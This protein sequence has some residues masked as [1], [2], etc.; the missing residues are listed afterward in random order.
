MLLER[1]ICI[2]MIILGV[3]IIIKPLKI[4]NTIRTMFILKEL[5]PDDIKVFMYR[6]V[7]IVNCI[8]FSLFFL[9]TFA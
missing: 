8:I 5:E 1:T 4:M 2:I 9:Q 6:I 7:G 3:F